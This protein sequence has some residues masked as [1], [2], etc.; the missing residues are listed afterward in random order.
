MACPWA[1]RRAREEAS[2]LVLALLLIALVGDAAGG[3]GQDAP[4]VHRNHGKF[5][6][7]PWR[8]AHATFYGGRDGAYMPVPCCPFDKRLKEGRVPLHS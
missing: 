6:A 7:G 3:G 5:T 1:S 4:K 8:Q 2:L